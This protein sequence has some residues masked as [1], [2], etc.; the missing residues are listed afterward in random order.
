MTRRDAD[1]PPTFRGSDFAARW[2][3]S[4]WS[5]ERI[6]EAINAS[7]EF[8]AIPYGRSGIGPDATD[9]EAVKEYWKKFVEVEGDWK[10]PDFLVVPASAHKANAKKWEALGDTTIV[11]DEELRSI[12]DCAI[13]GVEG[14]NSLWVAEQM[15][16]F[17][18]TL[19]LTK[20][21][22]LVAPTI[23]VKEEDR[24]PLQQWSKHFG[25]PIVVAQIFFDRGYVVELNTVLDDV[26]R[27]LAAQGADRTNLQKELGVLI[28]EQSYPD[29][30]TG[31]P[32]VKTAYQAH[33]T[34][35]VC[36]GI[37]IEKPHCVAKAK[38]ERNGKIIPYVAFHGGRME[39]TKEAL[40]F[41]RN[42]KKRQC[43][44]EK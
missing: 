38:P 20:L 42:L 3:Q 15:P 32:K 40:E 34:R 43:C 25:I 33:H 1:R 12:L 14:E 23:W 2:E 39:I 44:A 9:K 4:R 13:C 8:V 27:I 10:R 36:F 5:E 7:H 28:T 18:S 21:K 6:Q 17:N 22:S 41:F 35:G 31:V 19:P 11:A 24:E 37:S 29:A 30:R 26:S 16:D